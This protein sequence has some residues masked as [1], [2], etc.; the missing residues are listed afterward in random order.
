[1]F[2]PRILGIK[3][4]P[5]VAYEPAWI[6]PRSPLHLL[7]TGL[8]CLFWLPAC[9]HGR[10]AA[11]CK[12]TWR[13]PFVQS[14]QEFHTPM[15][16]RPQLPAFP[17][18][19]ASTRLSSKSAPS[20]T[21]TTPA[22]HSPPPPFQHTQNSGSHSPN[23]PHPARMESKFLTIL[24]VFEIVIRT[25]APAAFCRVPQVLE[26]QKVGSFASEA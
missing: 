5:L 26:L 20:N 4:K 23:F 7:P 9:G 10:L 1:M 2:S 16:P 12:T 18:K 11:G 6:F 8:I 22:P 14:H 19:R 13:A 17:G 21:H 25:G 15:C 24:I 3:R